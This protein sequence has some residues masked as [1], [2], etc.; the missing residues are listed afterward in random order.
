[1]NTLII[2]ALPK[3]DEEEAFY[4]DLAALCYPGK[5]STPIET[6]RFTGADN[7]RYEKAFNDIIAAD[8]I[9]A[10]ASTP[11]TGQGMELREAIHQRKKIIVIAREG[12]QV[13]GLIKGCPAIPSVIYYTSI[14][15]LKEKLFPAKT[16]PTT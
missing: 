9:I 1:M 14:E 2:G 16:E 7:E 12:S 13:S 4:E 15:E 5:V 8:R 6:A 10:E 11:S 3:S